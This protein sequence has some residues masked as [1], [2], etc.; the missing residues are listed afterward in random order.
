M[1]LIENPPK[2]NKNLY[3]VVEKLSKYDQTLIKFIKAKWHV[4]EIIQLLCSAIP[5]LN[6]SF[7]FE[8]YISFC[9]PHLA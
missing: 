5:F 2:R 6:L 4:L 8:I 1:N 3:F 9:I 7:Y